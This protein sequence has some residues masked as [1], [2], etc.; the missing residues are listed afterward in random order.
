MGI[1]A[2][3]ISCFR[4]CLNEKLLSTLKK[5]Q[6]TKKKKKQKTLK[7]PELSCKRKF[8]FK[9]QQNPKKEKRK[10]LQIMLKTNP[11]TLGTYHRSET[12]L[13]ENLKKK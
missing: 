2:N 7:F 13:T 12:L 1:E 10:I 6:K 5:T 9:K 8:Y 4:S 11:D 3:V